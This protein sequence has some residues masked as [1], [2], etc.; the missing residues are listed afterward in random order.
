M[1][2]LLYLPN[3]LLKCIWDALDSESDKDSLGLVCRR[4]YNNL[5]HFLYRHAVLN[6]PAFTSRWAAKHGREDTLL[7]MIQ[8]GFDIVNDVSLLLSTLMLGMGKK[9]LSG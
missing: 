2:T 6:H 9:E 5:N 1:P 3:E 8:E 4:F 7:K